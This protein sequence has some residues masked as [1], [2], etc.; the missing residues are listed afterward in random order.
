MHTPC[1]EP[2]CPYYATYR[3][4]CQRHATQRERRRERPLQR[5]VYNRRRWSTTRRRQLTDHPMCQAEGCNDIACDVHHIK[6][7]SEGGDPWDPANLLSLCHACHS[8]VT[9]GGAR[10]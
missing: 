10:Y 9:A 8:K 7:L 4:K 1:T 6:D 3:G 2:G 5:A